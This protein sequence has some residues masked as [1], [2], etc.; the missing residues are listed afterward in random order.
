[1]GNAQ[2]A[3]AAAYA[4]STDGIPPPPY[5]ETYDHTSYPPPGSAPSYHA[6]E[7]SSGA[8]PISGVKL[9]FPPALNA[10][11]QMGFTRTFHLGERKETP[12]FAARMHSG[13]TKN[14]DLVLYDGPSDKDPILAT[15]NHESLWKSKNTIITAPARE[16]VP[17][18][19][20]SQQVTMPGHW[21]LKSHTFTFTADVGVGKETRRETF[22]WRTSRGGEVKELDGYRWGWKLRWARD[23]RRMGA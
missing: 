22:E 6:G 23:Y 16:G 5:Q 18:D 20:Q 1:M 9:K 14:P 11:L 8:G 19:S 17:H 13:F 7:S 12:L 3:E 21:S 15:A 4:A 10:Y 2:E